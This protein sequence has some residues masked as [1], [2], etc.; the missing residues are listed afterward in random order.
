MD[1]LAAPFD[2]PLMIALDSLRVVLFLG[3][4]TLMGAMI[5]GALDREGTRTPARRWGALAAAVALVV[6]TGSRLQNLGQPPAWQLFLSAG[7]F[8][9]FV[10]SL[11]R[12]RREDADR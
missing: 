4:M 2:S 3:G 6:L 5:V 10:I 11:E 1:P 8:V 9:L 7:A 12:Y